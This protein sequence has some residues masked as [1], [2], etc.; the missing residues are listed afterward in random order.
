E[1][2][3]IPYNLLTDGSITT[4]TAAVQNGNGYLFFMH[5][6]PPLVAHDLTVRIINYNPNTNSWQNLNE[7]KT[8]YFNIRHSFAVNNE[9]ILS[10]QTGIVEALGLNSREII[11][12]KYNL[13]SQTLTPISRP[14]NLFQGI[15]MIHYN[16]QVYFG[17]GKRP[18]SP[19]EYRNQNWKYDPSLD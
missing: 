8:D 10:L 16:N 11:L 19:S 7:F 1:L 6:I 17:L 12:A 18:F 5:Y 3:D 14:F 2:A 13:S 9:V 15:F 4:T